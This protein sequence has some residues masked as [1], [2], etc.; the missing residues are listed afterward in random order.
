MLP[1]TIDMRQSKPHKVP[2]RREETTNVS[3]YVDPQLLKPRTQ[4]EPLHTGDVAPK[5]S[6][7]RSLGQ[8]SRFKPLK[9]PV[10]REEEK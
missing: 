10:I 6:D 5:H 4:Y 3:Q 8:F 9:K 2:T 7:D 1:M